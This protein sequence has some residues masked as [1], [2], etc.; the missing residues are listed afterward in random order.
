MGFHATANPRSAGA[1]T[2]TISAAVSSGYLPATYAT[3]D[4]AADATVAAAT[5]AA[6]CLN[7]VVSQFRVVT[8]LPTSGGRWPAFAIQLLLFAL[9]LSPCLQSSGV[10]SSTCA[11]MSQDIAAAD[12]LMRKG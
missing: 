7:S 8:P 12:V 2:A 9:M 11:W 6:K 3:T 10:P 1:T 5:V 4:D